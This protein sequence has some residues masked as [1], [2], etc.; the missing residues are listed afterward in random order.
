MHDCIEVAGTEKS[1]Q[2]GSIQQVALY[3]LSPRHG[4]TVPRGQIVEYGYPMPLLGQVLGH[5]AA[6]VARTAAYEN[7]MHGDLP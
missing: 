3:Q 4:A 2:S 1:L 5:V 7:V 6:D